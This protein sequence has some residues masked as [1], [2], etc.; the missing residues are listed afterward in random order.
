MATA[1]NNSQPP[2]DTISIAGIVADAV[3]RSLSGTS[4]TGSQPLPQVRASTSA[5]SPQISQD[6][7]Q[8]RIKVFE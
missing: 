1:G 4:G 3:R 6:G 8:G 7:D 2:L 5:G